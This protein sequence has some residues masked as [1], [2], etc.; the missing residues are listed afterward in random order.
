MQEVLT[1]A[2]KKMI[3]QILNNVYL[4]VTIVLRIRFQADPELFPGSCILCFRSK[5]SQNYKNNTFSTLKWA[6]H[7]FDVRISIGRSADTRSSW[8]HPLWAG[9]G[10]WAMA[11]TSQERLSPDKNWKKFIHNSVVLWSWSRYRSRVGPD[12]LGGAGAEK[13]GR[14]RF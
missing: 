1:K 5:S 2:Q 8:I 13:I 14:L 11:R 3:F 9:P 6:S 12:F 7:S 10:R 4:S